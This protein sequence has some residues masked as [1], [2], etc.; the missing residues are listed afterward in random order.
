M[1][2][3]ATGTAGLAPETGSIGELADRWIYVFMAGMFFIVVLTG[4]IPD[5]MG[6]LAAVEAGQRPPLPPILHMHAVVMGAWITLLLAQT[7]LMATGN[8][9]WHFR[10][11]LVSI[12][13]IPAMIFAMTGI[14]R[15]SFQMIASIPPDMMPPDVLD[16]LKIEISNIVLPQIRVI[17]LFSLFATWALLVRRTD[18]GLH[19]RLLILA[20]LMPLPA[21][22]DRITWLAHTTPESPLSMDLYMLLFLLPMF[23][24]DLLRSGRLHKAYVIF[25]VANIPFLFFTYMNWGTDW[26]LSTVPGL[27]GIENW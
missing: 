22:Y 5:S 8:R 21:A 17:A 23:I 1:A 2:T 3:Q 15:A 24:Y 13:L 16:G 11:G 25:V 14:M 20:T 19:K 26:W 27:F 18:S 4:F 6:M 12:G 9:A 7:T 10:L